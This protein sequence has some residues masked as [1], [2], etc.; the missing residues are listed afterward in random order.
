MG[1]GAAVHPG[2]RKKALPEVASEWIV[3]RDVRCENG[4][5]YVDKDDDPG[6]QGQPVLGQLD[7]EIGQ[8]SA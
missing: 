5:Q 6:Y 3:A 4:C 8:I 2:W 7:Q 1:H